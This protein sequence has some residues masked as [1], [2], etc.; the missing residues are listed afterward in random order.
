[1][2]YYIVLKVAEEYENFKVTARI[3]DGVYDTVGANG[4][5]AIIE[6]EEFEDLLRK[7]PHAELV[8]EISRRMAAEDDAVAMMPTSVQTIVP[9]TVQASLLLSEEV[10]DYIS[11]TADLFFHDRP[12]ELKDWWGN[13]Y[14]PK[15]YPVDTLVFHL[16]KPAFLIIDGTRHEVYIT[17]VGD[18]GICY[19]GG[20]SHPDKHA[21]IENMRRRVVT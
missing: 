4:V 13:L 14:L 3:A 7:V 9:L 15:G 10:P 17:E 18:R 5:I 12:G 11:V 1:M 19:R 16:G 8:K 6:I 21:I 2:A 20:A